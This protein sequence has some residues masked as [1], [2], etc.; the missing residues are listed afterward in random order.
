M[1]SVTFDILARDRASGA[2]R[3]VGREAGG[4]HATL[5][6]VGTAAKYAGLAL[7]GAAVGGL[8]AVLKTGFGEVT[9]YQ[10]GLAQLQAG[11]K[12]TGHV[13]GISAKGMEALASKIQG[14]SGQ[15]DDSIVAAE[16]Q[17]VTFPK[18]RNELGK[19]NDIFTQTTKITADYVART[20]RDASG[21]A[22]MFGKAL[23]D[24]IKGLSALSR[25]GI[26]V[27]DAQTAQIKS[28]VAAGNT[29]G[30]QK[31]ILKELTTEYG[32]SAKAFG[33]TLPGQIA[34]AKRAFE[35]FS[36]N[37]VGVL[38]PAL[39]KF[40]AFVS[41]SVI[42][43]VQ[44]FA[45]EAATR[46]APVVAQIGQVF[47]TKL[48]PAFQAAFG[49]AQTVILPVLQ[50]IAAFIVDK[51]VPAIV[52]ILKPAIQGLTDYFRTITQ[53]VSEHHDQLAAVGKVMAKVAGF[54]LKTLAPV[55]GETLKVTFK[56]LGK[57][58]TVTIDIIAGIIKAFQK[59]VDAAQAVVSWVKSHW[60]YLAGALAGPFGI[61]VVA[62]AKHW[63]SIK[64][65]ATSVYHW[66]TGKFH[67][68]IGF[69]TDLPGKIRNATVGMWDGIKDAFRSAINWI[70][71]G[72][73]SLAFT[74]PKV[75]THIPGV[76][77]VGGW[78]LSTP[79]IQPLAKGGIVTRPTV[80]LIGEAG[81][82]AVVPLGRFGGDKAILNELQALRREVALLGRTVPHNHVAFHD[83]QA[84]HASHQAHAKGR[85]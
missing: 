33:E 36:Q 1:S 24:P 47:T 12:S 3:S 55:I 11:L 7:G 25:V 13:A 5:G 32:G 45:K 17:L 18:I 76:G 16:A 21:A 62:I 79:D 66:V 54:V 9:D 23:N 42:P 19:N 80:A 74:L 75:N 71:S 63:T 41:S 39:S 52:T 84:G 49:Y 83:A 65:G 59:I 26:Q 72:W 8:A 38:V 64:N 60:P 53:A 48:V 70:I 69:F 51:V 6:K 73:N 78:T 30:A 61:A 15:T 29:M 67:D 40:A 37:A 46:L 58:I 22:I 28:M 57:T 56:I 4:L 43:A 2:F 77:T 44:A 50:S 31:I 34:K 85:K 68:L 10:R 20:G 81:P 27:G 14:Y 82:E 35:D